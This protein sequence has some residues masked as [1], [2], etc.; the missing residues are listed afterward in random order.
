[1]SAGIAWRASL[2]DVWQLSL[3]PGSVARLP[4]P[5]AWR[6]S[7]QLARRSGLYAESVAAAAS[8]PEW[9]PLDDSAAFQRKLRLVTLLDIVDLHWSR[10]HALDAWPAQVQIAGAWPAQGAFVAI[11]FHYGTGLWLCRALRRAGHK[12]QF[13]SARFERSAFAR[14]PLLYRYG[15]QRLAEVERIGGEPVARRPGVRKTLLDT[16]ARGSAV[17][18]LID[19][20]PRLA[21]HGQHPVSLLGQPASLPDGLLRLAAVAGVPVVP[22]WVEVDFTSGERR[23]VI[24][25]AQSP[26]PAEAVLEQLAASLDRLIRAEPG[27]WHFWCEW[28]AWLRDAAPLHAAGFSNA[29]AKGRL[30]ESAAAGRSP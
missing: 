12:S 18:G 28:P 8:A 25:Q 10:R 9:L 1:M 19:V 24:G 20:P 15:V 17:I 7:Q 29:A 21:P 26:Q 6:L 3:A 22:C 23:V 13:L 2:G 4:W 16:L 30:Q 5:L 27:A 14:R 11:T